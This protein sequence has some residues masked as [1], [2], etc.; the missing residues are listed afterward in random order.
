MDASTAHEEHLRDRHVQLE[1]EIAAEMK[2]RLPDSIHLQELKKEKLAI[3][4]ELAHLT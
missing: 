3:K 1:K 2:H 4:S